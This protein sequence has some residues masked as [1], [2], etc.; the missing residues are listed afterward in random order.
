ML[1]FLDNPGCIYWHMPMYFDQSCPNSA[2]FY[3]FFLVIAQLCTRI[4][5][6]RSVLATCGLNHWKRN[7]NQLRR[8]QFSKS[9]IEVF[10]E[11]VAFKYTRPNS[12]NLRNKKLQISFSIRMYKYSHSFVKYSSSSTSRTLNRCFFFCQWIRIVFK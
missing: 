10:H 11:E 6:E 7:E 5:R 1:Q 4:S 12:G 9:F 2:K 3:Y 8:F